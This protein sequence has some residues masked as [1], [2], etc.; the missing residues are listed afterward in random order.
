MPIR[1]FGVWEPILKTDFSPPMSWALGRLHDRRVTQYWD[2]GH[3]LAKQM[4]ADARPPQPEPECCTSKSIL[5]D[6]IAV[7]PKGAM[8]TEQMPPAVVFDGPVVDVM[9]AVESALRK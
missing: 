6:L 7:Y 3:V 2:K 8:W 1:V 4:A 5:W 9:T